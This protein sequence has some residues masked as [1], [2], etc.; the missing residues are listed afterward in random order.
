MSTLERLAGALADRYTIERE[1][2]AG[3]MATVYLA[4]DLKHDR[5][6]AI[7]VLKPELAAV[8]G[9]DRFVVEIKT[10]AAL[11][12]PHILPLF[13]S[14]SADGFLFYVMPFIQGET[15]RR[16][17]DRE[18]QFGIDEAIRIARDVA[19]ALDYAH[20]HG[21][22]HRDIKP[23][24]I[25][26]HDGRPMV[27][28]FGIALALSAAAGGRMTETGLSLGTPHYMSPEQ[29]TADKEI[30]GRS[31]IYSLGSVLYEML[32][33]NPPHV[34]NSAQ[35]I[36]MKIIAESVE[37]VT[38]YRKSVPPNVAAAV[39]KSLEK[40]PADRFESAKAFAEALG[41]TAFTTMHAT[42][43]GGG[44]G[45]RS[46]KRAFIAMSMVAAVALV[47]AG[48]AWFRPTPEPL[49]TRQHVQVLQR[50][51]SAGLAWLLAISPDGGAMV[52]VDTIGGT[53]QLWLKERDRLDATPLAGTTGAAAPTFSPDG[54]SIVFV[55]EGK[56]K[57]VP[58]LGGSAITVADSAN[59]AFPAIA[60]LDDGTILF[61]APDYSLRAI[62][63][64]GGAPR[65]F[66]A[67]DSLIRG[68]LVLT[69]LPGGRGALMTSCTG[70]CVESD[71][72]V[73]D[74]RSGEVRILA[75]DALQG[76]YVASGDVVFARRDGGVFSAPFDLK[77]LA[78]RSAPTP[79]LDGVRANGAAADMV[80]TP[81]GTLVYVAGVGTGS[82]GVEAVWVTREGV[83]SLIDSSWSFIEVTGGGMALS[84]TGDRL[85]VTSLASGG[86]D[87]WI[88]QLPAGPFTRLS[89]AGQNFRPFWTA[90]GRSVAY[91]SDKA[92]GNRDLVMQRADGSGAPVVIIDAERIIDEAI[93]TPDTTRF[94]VRLSGESNDLHLVTRSADRA[95]TIPLVA[96]ERFNERTPA[97][98]PDGRYLAYTSNESGRFEV[99]VRPYPNAD[100]GKWQVSRDG[101]EEPKW[102]H[103]GRELFY[104]NGSR[105]LVAANVTLGATFVLG[106]Q[107]ALF[108]TAGYVR[109]S[110]NV[111][112]DVAP[113]DRRF[114]F[115]RFV[116]TGAGSGGAS[117]DPLTVVKVDNWL[118][119]LKAGGARR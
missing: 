28:D 64:D 17:L 71:L 62:S 12:H 14:G 106:E 92:E 72:R 21:V 42:G 40:L 87:I 109:S 33:G 53:Q 91:L 86:E 29:A 78:F 69:P 100:G 74:L 46:Y 4:Q 43:V 99:F 68:V 66:S 19:D 89:F 37:P 58:R 70:G 36:I 25:L 65:S 3:G 105:E 1:L 44:V 54:E 75:D 108:S 101:G 26:L 9:A 23:E 88:K 30:S 18:T 117:S 95:A 10:T 49:V 114:L 13:D 57:R 104:R 119:E 56:V 24:N 32:A 34:G 16:K 47:A 50:P 116:G 35:Q 2:G 59:T 112:Y 115:L 39:A 61:T 83:A 27:A 5:Q 8:L 31:D 63:V 45:G 94:V 55:A 84:P 20:R 98:S 11:Q 81:N 22:V 38:K 48:V 97:L 111:R 82:R 67:L 60:W 80:L 107:R 77:T 96:S 103:S 6:V 110:T 73:I 102:S 118:T 90:D 76:W 113:D 41:N 51:V 85:A 7:K 15:L 52:Y 79:V 93:R